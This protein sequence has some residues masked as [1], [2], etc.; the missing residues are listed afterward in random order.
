MLTKN[1]SFVSLFAIATFRVSVFGYSGI[2]SG[3]FT[4]GNYFGGDSAL[5]LLRSIT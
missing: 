2:E 3:M 1:F 4:F 5:L